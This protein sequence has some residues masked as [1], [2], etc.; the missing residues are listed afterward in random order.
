[1]ATTRQLPAV[2]LPHT[3]SA[4]SDI[5]PSDKFTVLAAGE[6]GVNPKRLVGLVSARCGESGEENGPSSFPWSEDEAALAAADTTP[7][8]DANGLPSN[9]PRLA[10][11]FSMPVPAQLGHLKHPHRSSSSSK[12][13]RIRAYNDISLE[14]ADSVQLAI[15][16]ILQL[17]P[18][19]LLDTAKEQFAAC[20]VQMPTASVSALLTFM[21]NL[22][23][24]SANLSVLSASSP[25]Q[26]SSQAQATDF[27]VGE[28]LQN[29]GDSLGGIA[30]AADVELVLF[31]ADIGMKHISVHGDECGLSYALTYAVRQVLDVC[32][33]GDTVELGLQIVT[34]GAEAADTALSSAGSE[35]PESGSPLSEALDLDGPLHLIFEV[36]H[37]FGQST[38]YVPLLP[39]LDEEPTMWPPQ[40]ES[41]HEQLTE[42]PSSPA[43]P[44]SLP[45]EDR[46][47]ADF[48]A[49]ILQRI[50]QHIGATL[51][52]VHEHT[53]RHHA[54]ISLVVPRG[55]PLPD[56]TDLS[57]EDEAIRQPFPNLQLAREPTLS[58]L[59]SFT[60][61][62]RGNK[63]LFH[64]SST[65]SFAR[66]LSSYLT[67]WGMDVSHVPTD[68]AEGSFGLGMPLDGTS[69][70]SD[71]EEGKRNQDSP[72]A[73]ASGPSM[74]APQTFIVIDDDVHV[75][76]RRLLQLR[77]QAPYIQ[78][79]QPRRQRPALAVHHRPRSYGSRTFSGLP[80][81]HEPADMNVVIIHF[82]SLSNYKIVKDTLQ[83][84]LST[85]LGGGAS[86]T[87]EVLIIPKPAGPR[88]FLTAIY[89]A[90]HKP[91]VDPFFVPIATSPAQVGTPYSTTA[92]SLRHRGSTSTTASVVLGSASSGGRSPRMTAEGASVQPQTP[93]A[94]E[95]IEYFSE[96]AANTTGGTPAAGVVIQSPDG[97][98]AGIFFQ[99]QPRREEQRRRARQPMPTGAKVTQIPLDP[100]KMIRRF[101]QAIS[102]LALDSQEIPSSGDEGAGISPAPSA[103]GQAA[104]GLSLNI[105]GAV[106]PP[107][108][109]SSF[110][111]PR[112]SS[113]VSRRS[114]AA[115][116][117]AAV[118]SPPSEKTIGR[119][120][121][122]RS[123]SI[124][125]PTTMPM[126]DAA[127]AL[128]RFATPPTSRKAS[129]A[130][131]DS[132]TQT[133]NPPLITQ[134]SSSSVGSAS[135]RGTGRKSL[136]TA[137]P[138]A[139]DAAPVPNTGAPPPSKVMDKGKKP[140]TKSG[141]GA[142]G[143]NDDV[144]PPVSVLIVEDNPI[145][146]NILSHA[147]TRMGVKHSQAGNGQ[148]ALDKWRKGSFH[149]ILMDIHM[150]VMDGIT[151]TREIRRCEHGNGPGQLPS[152]SLLD[153]AVQEPSSMLLPPGGGS[154]F[155]SSV[156]IVALTA[157][158]LESDRLAALAAGCN[159]YITKPVSLQWLRQKIMEWGSIKMLQMWADVPNKFLAEQD[160]KAQEIAAHLKLPRSRGTSPDHALKR[161]VSP[162][163]PSE[164]STFG[165]ASE[166]S[167]AIP[168]TPED[169]DPDAYPTLLE[170][171]PGDGVPIIPYNASERP[172][173]SK[174]VHSSPDPTATLPG[175]LPP[176][177]VDDAVSIV[178]TLSTAQH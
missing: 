172:A 113:A 144:V 59:R 46:R 60:E 91:I 34:A 117:S 122:A 83:S 148:E 142:K 152:P 58:E 153:P 43:E 6:P 167:L 114:S 132:P 65:G 174:D 33:P 121:R 165:S 150:P 64:A 154:P 16:T 171:Q 41:M 10:R 147:L 70:R 87:P 120:A 4:T 110:T 99:P 145:N 162:P 106:V 73:S 17:V 118:G 39:R 175:A 137:A 100:S 103:S 168:P 42:P 119:Y 86:Y 32:R 173:G 102:P 107:G 45:Q 149:L 177:P 53:N 31:H 123:P 104:G 38:P 50:L 19:H 13:A 160:Q 48:S 63:V 109:S 67:S 134:A 85:P 66:H 176:T 55:G 81:I 75:L 128:A 62:L 44:R 51:V 96:T 26:A 170:P 24:I 68:D 80:Q 112:R 35:S 29:V 71:S 131:S 54:M 105:P 159:D 61:T 164:A 82:T 127:Q 2:R 151:A 11:A 36:I 166:E 157:S 116:S 156:I 178:E 84:T 23:Y 95:G 163:D 30:A 28:M 135:R 89:T 139:E 130:P 155:R 7:T 111:S 27:D 74:P 141:L 12:D 25:V 22:N 69:V 52:T 146:R 126:N 37:R 47:H 143:K 101:N 138:A 129:M 57:P 136:D 115:S 88:R 125:S 94:M 161:P 93:L 90:V 108:S 169:V 158:N 49:T 1:M 97:R 20:S 3:L 78:A 124:P 40:S 77:A 14:L 72:K 5:L 92:P 21:K 8:N 76:R 140:A 18:P 79:Q 15:Q 133:K 9:A 98:P 56:F